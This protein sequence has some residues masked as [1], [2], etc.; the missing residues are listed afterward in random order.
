MAVIDEMK[1]G[2]S[3]SSFIFLILAKSVFGFLS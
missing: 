3:V 1:G 2:F